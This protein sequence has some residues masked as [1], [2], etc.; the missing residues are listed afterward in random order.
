VRVISN[1]TARPLKIPLP[2]GKFLH[3]GPLKTAEISDHAVE[4]PPIRK[5]VE[6]GEIEIL[7][8]GEHPAAG[9]DSGSA[10][11]ESTQGHRP[12]THARPK[13]NR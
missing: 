3:L 6:A 12:G 9:P 8:V 2:G 10:P 1:K 7:G 13:G 5:L 11:H 4:H